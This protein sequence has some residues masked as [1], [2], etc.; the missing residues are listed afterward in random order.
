MMRRRA[1]TFVARRFATDLSSAQRAVSIE[2]QSEKEWMM[3]PDTRVLFQ[4]WLQSG[5]LD[6]ID[7]SDMFK[8]I[9]MRGATEVRANSAMFRVLSSLLSNPLTLAYGLNQVFPKNVKNI[10]VLAIGMRSESQLPLGWWREALMAVPA[11][12]T[13]Q[14]EMIG[15]EII[16]K[17]DNPHCSFCSEKTGRVNNL[18]ISAPLENKVLFHEHGSIQYK[19]LKADTFLLF[20]PGFAAS[21]IMRHQWK[22]TLT[23]LLNSRKPIIC[24]AHS[25]ADL[26]RDTQFIRELAEQENHTK[27]GETLEIFLPPHNNPFRSHV[28]TFDP[29]ESK[30]DFV[31]STNHSIYAFCMK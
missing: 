16:P 26:V 1:L 5:P 4:S 9:C 13:I 6:H 15:P 8:Y 23:I 10:S 7:E 2:R 11:I 12:D 19:L 25:E 17:H 29:N 24:T 18:M 3:L 22:E 14:L 27:L 28:K 20:N 21:D 31:V 30:S